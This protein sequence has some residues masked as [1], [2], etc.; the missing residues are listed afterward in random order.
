MD[1]SL[2][3]SYLYGGLAPLRNAAR[4]MVASVNSDFDMQGAELDEEVDILDFKANG[5]M[6]HAPA[7][8]APEPVGEKAPTV[9]KVKLTHDKDYVIKVTA[10]DAAIIK[11]IGFEEWLNRMVTL[12]IMSFLD[13][14]ETSLTGLHTQAGYAVGVA[15]A[16]P[17]AANFD[18]M[19]D[20]KTTMTTELG[21]P[22]DDLHCIIGGPLEN[23]LRKQDLFNQVN[24][25]G[26]DRTLRNGE[27]LPLHG[28][29]LKPSSKIQSHVAGVPAPAW[30]TN[31][32][33]WLADERIIGMD[34]GTGLVKAGDV[35]TFAGDTQQYVN[36][37]DFNADGN[38]TLN[39]G[40]R[41]PLA[42]G[43]ASTIVGNHT[44]NLAFHRRSVALAMRPPNMPPHGDAATSVEYITL[45]G[46]GILG[47]M[48]FMLAHYGEFRQGKYVLSALWGE[49]VTEPEG[50]FKVLS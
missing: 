14:M 10:R 16:N 31:G 50:F 41:S 25:A 26:T 35:L 7:A 24:T 42:D 17:F 32:A 21:L 34:G 4:G 45:G 36:S 23:A 49:A 37:A 47:K 19:S 33:G 13:A 43:V 28:F 18:I 22:D 39:A 30:S 29:S 1:L 44:A 12:G 11:R 40:L 8:G 3:K 46:D 6:D 27:L 38:L 5:M 9:S 48:T 15:G 2:I 20:L